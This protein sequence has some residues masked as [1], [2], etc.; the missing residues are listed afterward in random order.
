MKL[1]EFDR[2]EIE[3]NEAVISLSH[4]RFIGPEE[5]K[6]TIIGRRFGLQ[7]MPEEQ[8]CCMV[9]QLKT[10]DDANPENVKW[11][12]LAMEGEHGSWIYI[13]KSH[14]YRF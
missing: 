5:F 12:R 7:D 6:K 4:L 9:Y 8:Y 3:G 13:D 2:M 1:R 10:I 11:M 14:I